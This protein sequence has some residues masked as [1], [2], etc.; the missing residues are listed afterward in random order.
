MT[1]GFLGTFSRGLGQAAPVT[2]FGGVTK[3]R[4]CTLTQTGQAAQLQSLSLHLSSQFPAPPRGWSSVEHEE[5]QPEGLE[6]C[7]CINRQELLV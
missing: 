1:L 3:K 5:E 2:T 7:P 4:D 6:V